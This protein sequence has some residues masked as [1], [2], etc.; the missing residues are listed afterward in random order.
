MKNFHDD[1]P[2]YISELQNN[3]DRDRM[4]SNFD[5]EQKEFFHSVKDNV[6]TFCESDAGTGKTTIAAAA[7]L[8]MLANGEINKI[9][10]I[11]V[12]DDRIQSIGYYPGTIE[13]KTAPYWEPFYEALETL[14]LQQE[15]IH[16]MEYAN[17]LNE[18]LDIT[19]RGIN[20][21][22]AGVIVDELQNANTDTLR[23]IFTRMHDDCH[24]A[25]IGDGKQKDQKHASKDFRAYCDFLAASSFGNKCKLTHNYR[26]K[27]SKLAESFCL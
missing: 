14:G 13:E 6:F 20:L 5:A 7:M 26:G 8:D 18:S 15:T 9:V 27:F 19:M 11:R 22:K 12:V 4:Y 25:A 17:L 21:E 16:S 1:K 23:L 3:K 10:Y 24:I 2:D